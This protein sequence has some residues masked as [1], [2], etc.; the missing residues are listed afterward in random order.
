M[1]WWRE[2]WG[3]VAAALALSPLCGGKPSRSVHGFESIAAR[4]PAAIFQ[5]AAAAVLIE[6]RCAQLGLGLQSCVPC[7]LS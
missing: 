3:K 4:N 1:A 6:V 5:A 7:D 2:L